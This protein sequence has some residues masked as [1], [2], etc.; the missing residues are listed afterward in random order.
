M[1]QTV[2]VNFRLD[3]SVKDSMEKACDEMGLSMSAAFTM[4]AKKVSREQRIPFEIS[5]D[6][7]YSPNNIHHLENIMEE[8]GEGKAHFKEHNL[9]KVDEQ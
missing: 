5:V 3:K 9:V 8:V 7:F 4:F 6:P 1:G 2:N